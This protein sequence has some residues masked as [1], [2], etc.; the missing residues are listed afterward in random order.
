[1]IAPPTASGISIEGNR[2]WILRSL[3]VSAADIFKAKLKLQL[4]IMWPVCVIA[5]GAAAFALGAGPLNAAITILLPMAYALFSGLVGLVTN[6]MLPMLNWKT[7][8]CPSSAAAAFC[9]AWSSGLWRSPC[10][11]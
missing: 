11:L 8:W 4:L 10:P 5:G 7:P 2:L 6:L 3:P 9:S 1:M